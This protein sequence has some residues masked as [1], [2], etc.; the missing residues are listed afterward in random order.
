VRNVF[1]QDL[2]SNF[3]LAM[4]VLAVIAMRTQ[5]FTPTQNETPTPCQPEGTALSMAQLT[6]MEAVVSLAAPASM[7]PKHRNYAVVQAVLP[8]GSAGTF[9]DVV[10]PATVTVI[11]KGCVL[12]TFSCPVNAP[13]LAT[14]AGK[15]TQL[16]EGCDW[17][18]GAVR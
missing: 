15:V 6:A 2:F 13:R 4:V 12:G 17:N 14:R 1:L 16:V 10:L 18:W 8:V 9:P 5:T 7:N 11:A 3:L